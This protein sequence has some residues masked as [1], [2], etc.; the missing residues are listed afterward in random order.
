M[1]GIF[2]FFACIGEYQPAKPANGCGMFFVVGKR[3]FVTNIVFPTSRN[4]AKARAFS[5]SSRVLCNVR[6]RSLHNIKPCSKLAHRADMPLLY[7]LSIAPR[8][9]DILTV[10]PGPD[11]DRPSLRL[12]DG[13]RTL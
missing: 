12:K 3:C 5:I 9:I 11:I 6:A 7:P 10:T 4:R 2:F 8:C 1:S 13:T